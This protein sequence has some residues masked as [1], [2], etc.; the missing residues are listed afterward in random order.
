MA[1]SD[2]TGNTISVYFPKS[3][4]TG[5]ISVYAMPTGDWEIRTAKN[6]FPDWVNWSQNTPGVPPMAKTANHTIPEYLG[7]YR[8]IQKRIDDYLDEM[9]EP[10]KKATG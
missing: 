5:M 10:K 3:R 9:R 7:F 8:L 2:P 6:Q 1:R 4:T